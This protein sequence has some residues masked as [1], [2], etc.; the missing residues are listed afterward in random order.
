LMLGRINRKISITSVRFLLLLL[1]IH[2]ILKQL[3]EG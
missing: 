1:C 3:Q 2:N